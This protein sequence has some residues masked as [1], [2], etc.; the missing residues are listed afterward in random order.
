MDILRN[1]RKLAASN[2]GSLDV[3]SSAKAMGI[4]GQVLVL[5]TKESRSLSGNTWRLI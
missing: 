4:S 2:R 3:L 1:G 5:F